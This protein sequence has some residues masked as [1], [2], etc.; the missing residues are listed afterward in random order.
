VGCPSIQG[1]G[2]LLG[3]IIPLIDRGDAPEFGRLVREQLVDGDGI[4][5]EARQ[6]RC[7]GPPENVATE[8]ALNVLGYNLTRV[9]SIVGVKPLLAAMR[10]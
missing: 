1:P 5:A 9:M 6:R 4:E 8:M 3:E 7:A 10:A 2:S